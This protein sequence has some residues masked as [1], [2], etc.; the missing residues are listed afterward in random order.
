MPAADL[1]AIAAQGL[2]V[3]C[4]D[5]C[6]ALDLLRNPAREEIKPH[7]R[8]AAMDLLA[9]AE[10]GRVTFLMADQ[11]AQ[12]IGNNL[13]STEGD[14]VK[15]LARL[16][17]QVMRVHA[18][19]LAYGGVGRLNLD[20]LDD[21]VV[22]ARGV[23]DRWMTCARQVSQ[24][25]DVAARAFL[26]VTQGRAPARKGK[27]SMKDCVIVETYL[28]AVAGL[29]SV[30]HAL[31]IVFASSNVNDYTDSPGTRLRTDL[32]QDFAVV[33]L[34]YAPNCAAAKHLLGL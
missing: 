19:D 13:P 32:A 2:P 12:E 6:T 5:S 9:A 25:T 21:H 14:A 17:E 16:K 3:L 28:E 1:A 34:G 31:P 23:F 33:K 4:F 30:A 8:M 18:L 20:H 15:G 22:R 27:E 24:G 29:R 11:V 7:E 26:R 10:Q